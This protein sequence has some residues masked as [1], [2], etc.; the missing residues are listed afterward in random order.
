MQKV[1]FCD[2]YESVDAGK[3]LNNC[4]DDVNSMMHSNSNEL[5][6]GKN[7]RSVQFD[8]LSTV[9][10]E[11]QSSSDPLSDQPKE[12]HLMPRLAEHE[13]SLTPTPGN[14]TDADS[15]AFSELLMSGY[16]TTAPP[17][18]Y[19]ENLSYKDIGPTLGKFVYTIDETQ[20][21]LLTH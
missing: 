8:H 18:T 10:E 17:L 4:C 3:K 1:Q 9:S 16:Q 12:M 6:N 19:F 13:A 7:V 21:P 11:M 5:E 2:I 20:S 15:D 14:T